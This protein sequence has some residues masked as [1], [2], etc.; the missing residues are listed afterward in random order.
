MKKLMGF[1]GNLAKQLPVEHVEEEKV[2]KNDAELLRELRMKQYKPGFVDYTDAE[3]KLLVELQDK[4]EAAKKGLK[5]V[6]ELERNR[7]ME[8]SKK[9]ELTSFEMEEL[10]FLYDRTEGRK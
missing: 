10:A 8:L 5:P 3:R 7:F 2:E 6:S 1:E 4:E 9:N